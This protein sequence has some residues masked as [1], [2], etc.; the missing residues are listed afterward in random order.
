MIT[1][2]KDYPKIIRSIARN[3]Q[4]ISQFKTELIRELNILDIDENSQKEKD[5][6]YYTESK[7][8]HSHD[9]NSK[10]STQ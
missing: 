7:K 3:Y 9:A 4:K 2:P 5:S 8:E 10:P 1:N 6:I